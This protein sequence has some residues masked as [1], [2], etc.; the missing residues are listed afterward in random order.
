M[1]A[2]TVKCA[3]VVLPAT[4]IEAAG[5]GYVPAMEVL[6][7]V[8]SGILIAMLVHLNASWLR[9]VRE[10]AHAYGRLS[11]QSAARAA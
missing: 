6:F 8:A 11:G 3:T 5:L 4:A 9:V 10:P 2:L 7:A 1:G